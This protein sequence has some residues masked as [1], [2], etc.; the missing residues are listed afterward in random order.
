MALIFTYLM[1]QLYQHIFISGFGLLKL[2]TAHNIMHAIFLFQDK[3]HL[4]SINYKS[5]KH[6]NKLNIN[7][8]NKISEI[9]A[10]LGSEYKVEVTDF[11]ELISPFFKGCY[12]FLDIW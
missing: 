12:M 11:L 1:Q 8:L 9:N 2:V 10:T 5:L 4:H 7:C 3:G 6:D